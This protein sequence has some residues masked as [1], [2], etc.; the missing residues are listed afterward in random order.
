MPA[1]IDTG[2]VWQVSLVTALSVGVLQVLGLVLSFWLRR[3]RQQAEA[4]Q[5]MEALRAQVKKDAF[6]QALSVYQ[7]ALHEKERTVDLKNGVITQQAEAMELLRRENA[8]CQEDRA[9]QRS[10]IHFIYAQLCEAVKKAGR[11]GL[12]LGTVPELPPLRTHPPPGPEGAEFKVRQAQTA[13]E[14]VRELEGK[15]GGEGSGDPDR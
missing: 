6:E 3:S 14:L 15:G 11:L 9:E 12:D 2:S 5:K 8:N 10:A 4:D 7:D 1:F 13:K